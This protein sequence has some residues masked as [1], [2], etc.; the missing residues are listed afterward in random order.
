MNE[1]FKNY[2]NRVTQDSDGVYRWYYDMDMY[3]NKSMLHSLEKINLFTFLGVSIGGALLAELV[4]GN[5]SLARGILLIGL[6]MGALMALLYW[7]GFY[8]AAGI[9]HGN[10]RVH[11]AMREN[12]IE[13]VWSERLTE[14]MEI[15]RKAMALAGSAVGSSRV[16]GRWR[17][18]LEEVSKASFSTVVRCKSYPQ[19]DMID[20]SMLGGK[21]QVYVGRG[22][23]ERVETFIRER[24][25]GRARRTWRR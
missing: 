2:T 20:L 24:V 13:L 19:W 8:V 15:G 25:P 16:R 11:F 9:K 1:E 14:G 3:Q 12:G 5:A 17:P 21:F 18:T 6:G 22:D 23:F 10:Y 7:V 4:E